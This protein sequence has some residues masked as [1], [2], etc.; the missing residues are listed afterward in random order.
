MLAALFKPRPHRLLQAL[1]SGAAAAGPLHALQIGAND[2]VFVDPLH[3]LLLRH[4]SLCATRVEPVP[5]YFQRLQRHCA[6]AALAGR[7]RCIEAAVCG[8]DGTVAMVLPDPA[9]AL[10]SYRQ[11]IARLQGV[12]APEAAP[13]QGWHTIT[14]PALTPA[15]L[16]EQAL[17]P[18][19]DVYL[20]DCEGYDI[21]LAC[22]MPFARM[23]TRLVYLEVQ[24]ATQ[25]SAPRGE[26]LG[27]L[28]GLL[29]GQGFNQV[30]WDG[31]NL[32]AW[33]GP[34]AAG[35]RRPAL[36]PAA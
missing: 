34:P 13:H 11:G 25:P 14:V 30:V 33:K 9:T 27:R 22:L 19:V 17:A 32:I 10:G 4:R 5:A 21:E 1:I 31:F 26:Q 7:V 3:P 28:W 36:I 12:D 16:L 8:H 15:A 2:G 20:S 23:Q 6:T 29:G 35:S 18:R 24:A